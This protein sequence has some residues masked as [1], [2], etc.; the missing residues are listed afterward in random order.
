MLVHPSV[1]MDLVNDRHREWAA[2]ADR[3]RLLTLVRRAR[4]GRKKE[5]V[6][7]QP[8]GTLASCEQSA[9]VPAR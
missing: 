7:R 1:L 4:S 2:E 5:A 8:T 9:V 3:D 6:R